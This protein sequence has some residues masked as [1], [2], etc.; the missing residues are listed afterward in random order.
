VTPKSEVSSV[1]AGMDVEIM[2]T[3]KVEYI[4]QNAQTIAFLKREEFA[5]LDLKLD[6]ELEKVL[7]SAVNQSQSMSEAG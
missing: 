5:K 3:G 7:E 1:T 2:L 6:M 4:T